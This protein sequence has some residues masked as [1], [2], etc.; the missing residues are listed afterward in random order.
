MNKVHSS[1]YRLQNFLHTLLLLSGMLLLLAAI[2]W[3]IA[4][5][6]GVV[7]SLLM[8]MLLTITAPRLTPHLIL[9][10]YGARLLPNQLSEKLSEIITW[11]TTNS[12]LP[13]KPKL[14][15]I[16][17]SIMLA[18][19]VG[20]NNDTAIAISDGLLR[21]LNIREITAVLAHEISHI[22]SKDLW[23]MS[24]ADI[25]SRLTS[26]MALVAYMM[27][28]FY[29]PVYIFE[30]LKIP[31]V[32]IIL[33]LLAPIASSLMQLALSRTRE[34]NADVQAVKLT[35][36]PDG[37]ISA[38]LKIDQ[39][40]KSLIKQMFSPNIKTPGP[41]LLRTH[42]VTEERIQRLTLITEAKHQP[43]TSLELNHLLD[44]TLSH[45]K[46]KRHI[47]GLWH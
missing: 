39:Y 14:Y 11:L 26:L 10:L 15:Y 28:I 4:G 12:H 32:L 44:N 21:Q 20:R 13:Q 22:K 38:L 27:I 41:S 43:F 8:G 1:H 33:L 45:R 47:S 46:P 42:P 30:G 36:D 16:P 24:I 40:E 6:V 17:S 35:G 7:W 5:T 29:I 3:L 9:Y 34:F 19:T 37:L 31:Y 25:I 23:V 2:G 18:F